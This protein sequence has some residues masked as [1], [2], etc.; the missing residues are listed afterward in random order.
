MAPELRTS[1]IV[2]EPV[3]VP[4]LRPGQ[5]EAGASEG[6]ALGGRPL[7]ASWRLTPTRSFPRRVDSVS[8]RPSD[9]KGAARRSLLLFHRCGTGVGVVGQLGLRAVLPRVTP[10]SILPIWAARSRSSGAILLSSAVPAEGRTASPRLDR[11]THRRQLDGP[12]QFRR[13]R[14][15]SPAVPA[16]SVTPLPLR[17][18]EAKGVRIEAARPAGHLGAKPV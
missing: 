10:A 2:C 7:R 1:S 3:P 5:A 15:R 9:G 4:P 8:R 17:R 13:G 6:A 11:R 14:R 18:R 16:R 12:A